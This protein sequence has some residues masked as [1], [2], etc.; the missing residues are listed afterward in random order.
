M[1]W[2]YVVRHGKKESHAGFVAGALGVVAKVAHVRGVC[3]DDKA[4][5][6]SIKGRSLGGVGERDSDPAI[7]EVGEPKICRNQTERL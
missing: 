4:T 6:P 5:N 1:R 7:N 3:G 2:N